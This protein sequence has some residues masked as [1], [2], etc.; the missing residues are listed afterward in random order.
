MGRYGLCPPQLLRNAVDKLLRFFLLMLLDPRTCNA[1][2]WA[3]HHLD[4]GIYLGATD[5][6]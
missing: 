5:A 6:G 4:V 1:C 3:N 2:S